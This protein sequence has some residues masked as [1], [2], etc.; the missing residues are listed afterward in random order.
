MTEEEVT[1]EAKAILMI[2]ETFGGCQVLSTTRAVKER[3]E[4]LARLRGGA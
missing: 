4:L 2:I 3:T 1:A